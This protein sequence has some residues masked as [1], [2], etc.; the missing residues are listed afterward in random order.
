MAVELEKRG[1]AFYESLER[2]TAT[3]D[4]RKVFRFLAEEEKKH[5]EIFSRLFEDAGD[6]VFDSEGEVAQY[7]GAI[8]ESGVLAKVLH[9]GISLES[10]SLSEALDIGIQVEKE[11]IL[12]YQSF[13]PFVVPE[14]RSWVEKVVA[15]E[16]KH[17][18]H[19]KE[20]QRTLEREMA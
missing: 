7:L 14:K 20:L 15:E 3:E 1:V 19:L 6:M 9:G 18:L 17:F 8:V 2:R 4:G 10:T 12:F 16:Q 13:V 5:L 11:S